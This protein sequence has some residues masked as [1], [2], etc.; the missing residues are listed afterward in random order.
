[1]LDLRPLTASAIGRY[2][3]RYS[4]R[5]KDLREQSVVLI[6]TKEYGDDDNDFH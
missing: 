2:T 1:M 6:G 3:N 5:K 4:K